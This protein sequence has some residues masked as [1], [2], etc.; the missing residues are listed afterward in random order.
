MGGVTGSA[1]DLAVHALPECRRRDRM[2]RRQGQEG[3][4]QRR[5]GSG[6]E[7]AV[8]DR[9]L[10]VRVGAVAPEAD[11]LLG[12]SEHRGA[13]RSVALVARRAAAR[14]QPP[15]EVRI[16]ACRREDRRALRRAR[17]GASAQLVTGET[18]VF[19]RRLHPEMRDA[20]RY[21]VPVRV[22]IVTRR[23]LDLAVLVELHGAF[24]GQRLERQQAHVASIVG[25]GIGRG[26]RNRDRVASAQVGPDEPRASRSQPL[27]APHRDA[28]IPSHVAE[29]HRPVVAREAEP[30][31]PVGLRGR[32][33]RPCRF[34]S[35]QGRHRRQRRR[36]G[37]PR[38]APGRRPCAVRGR[39]CRP[40]VSVVDRISPG[41]LADRLW[42]VSTTDPPA[43]ARA[44]PAAGPSRQATRRKARRSTRI[45]PSRGHEPED[46]HPP[47]ERVDDGHSSV[48]MTGDPGGKRERTWS[49]AGSA[50]GHEVRA[51]PGRR[52]RPGRG[53]HP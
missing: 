40:A 2:L 46:L 35:R 29:R 21:V 17:R 11:V 6:R 19:H 15:V 8:R 39:T 32:P 49:R 41:P 25:P 30:R 45:R 10:E 18:Y 27:G 9:P 5:P 26:H 37:A 53:G 50:D 22:G 24:S 48:G 33:D 13:R 28:A 7:E 52:A 12:L 14:Q 44:T 31:R 38:E 34:P 1:D 23:A 47:A 36:G 51:A 43:C 3:R 42:S 4:E 16:P 20:A